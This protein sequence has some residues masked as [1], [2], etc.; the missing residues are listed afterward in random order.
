MIM[1][2]RF[3]FILILVLASLILVNV[4]SAQGPIPRTPRTAMGTGFTYQG[5]L[6][7]GGSAYTGNCDFQFKL[8]DDGGSGSQI[9]TTQTATSVAVTS[10]LFTT[11]IDFGAS[12]FNG[13]AR[14]LDISVRCPAGSGS[15]T[16]LSSR[17]QLTAA[18]YALYATTANTANTAS[19]LQGIPVASTAP[20]TGQVLE[21]DGSQWVPGN[22]QNVIVVAKSGGNYTT[23]TA[24]LNSITT[25]SDTNRY[26][27]KVMPG[28][29]TERVT[30]KQYVDIEGA[31]ELATKIT[32]T[33]SASADTGTVVGASNAELRFLGVENTGANDY[34][35]AIYNGSA[36]PRLTHITVRAFGGTTSR[37]VVNNLSSPRMTNMTVEAVGAG[38][39]YGVDNE[40][41][42]PMMTN[43]TVTASGGSNNRGVYNSYS[44]PTMTNATIAASGGTGSTNYGVHVYYATVTIQNST[45]SA[46]GGTQSYGVL[47]D[48]MN[49]LALVNNSKI[50][51]GTNAIKNSNTARVAASMLEGGVSNTGTLTCVYAYNSSYVGLG[52]ACN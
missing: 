49:G 12:A 22:Y 13:D 29:Y 1:R 9:G 2:M 17:Q 38:S 23:I 4:T 43:V 18:P 20:I 33:A 39:N 32:Y 36:S 3:G 6:K 28:V 45:I 48:Y 51:G 30:M 5:Q 10:G 24:A 26:L 37:P 19:K 27:I 41:G 34:A 21:Y 50:S 31:G 8:Y 7:S 40:G 46:S 44:T 47:N 52:P 16:P 25:A 14:W 35:I 15:Y 42:S 11:P